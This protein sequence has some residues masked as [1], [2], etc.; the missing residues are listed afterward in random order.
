MLNTINTR[1]SQIDEELRLYSAS[2]QVQNDAPNFDES[3]AVQILHTLV[4]KLLLF[5]TD[6]GAGGISLSLGSKL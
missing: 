3:T 5:M 4:P 6:Q 2:V 1:H